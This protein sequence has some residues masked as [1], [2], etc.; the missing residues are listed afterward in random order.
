MPA[1][2]SACG[3]R[4]TA[5]PTSPPVHYAAHKKDAINFAKGQLHLTAIMYCKYQ[6]RTMAE[7][8][9]K[10]PAEGNEISA[11]I[12]MGLNGLNSCRGIRLIG[13]V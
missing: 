9:H 11:E 1:L 8:M 3:Q 6:K 12:G 4:T 2:K 13:W 7:E 10:L 5:S